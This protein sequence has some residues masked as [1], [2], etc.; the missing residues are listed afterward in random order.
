[1][2]RK[3]LP[4]LLA[5]FAVVLMQGTSVSAQETMPLTNEHIQHI[6]D[7][8]RAADRTLTQLHASDALLRVNRGQLYDL[9]S[10]K[11]MARMNSRIALNRLDGA[12][13]VSAT[14]GFDST[15]ETFRSRYQ[16]Y[17]EQLSTTLHI[18]CQNKPVEFYQA[19]QRT[20]ELRGLVHEAIQGLG[21]YIGQYSR[22]FDTFRTTF[23]Q[24]N[25][26]GGNS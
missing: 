25:K 20:R 6:K 17:E 13:L 26:N 2:I 8:C 4:A 22:E 11:L 16:S 9:I 12:G 1:M 5:L 7:N 3:C 18:E 10:T 24:G 14:A 19:V 15:L 21:Q 23:N